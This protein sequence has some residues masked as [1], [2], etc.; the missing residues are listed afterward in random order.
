MRLLI[1]FSRILSPASLRYRTNASPSWQRAIQGQLK[2]QSFFLV[3]LHQGTVSVFVIRFRLDD[4]L[5]IQNVL[6]HTTEIV[7]INGLE[8]G[9]LLGDFLQQIV[10]IET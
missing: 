4:V 1:R 3:C 10:V 9:R 5:G 8:R 7:G 2:Q 6:I